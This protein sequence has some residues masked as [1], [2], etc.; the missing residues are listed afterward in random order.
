[1]YVLSVCVCRVCVNIDKDNKNQL[2]GKHTLIFY[3]SATIILLW[4]L[5]LFL[6]FSVLILVHNLGPFR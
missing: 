5:F 4:F 1:M 6:L 2:T 3:I